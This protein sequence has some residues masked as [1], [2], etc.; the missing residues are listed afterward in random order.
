MFNTLGNFFDNIVTNNR[1]FREL[2]CSSNCIG[3]LKN[4][5]NFER[6]FDIFF[7]TYM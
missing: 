5:G 2:L 4:E 7:E 1:D 6:T 3:A